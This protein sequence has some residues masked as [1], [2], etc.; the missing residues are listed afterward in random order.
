MYIG[1]KGNFGFIRMIREVLQNAIDEMV[2]KDSCGTTAVVTYYEGNRQIIIE[3]N[4]R[5]IPFGHIIRVFSKQHTGSNYEK[6]LFD[7]TSGTY[8]VGAK[9]SMALSK[10]FVVESSKK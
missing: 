7:Y 9:V 2:R 1:Y 3:D 8:G 6:K 10:T 5:G 4:G